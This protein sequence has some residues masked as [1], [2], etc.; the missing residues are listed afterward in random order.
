[1]EGKELARDRRVQDLCDVMNQSHYEMCIYIGIG[2]LAFCERR[3]L[4]AAII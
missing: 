2:S 3:D 1:M 4:K